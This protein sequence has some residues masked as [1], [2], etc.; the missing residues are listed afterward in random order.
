MKYNL[1]LCDLKSLLLPLIHWNTLKKS[2]NTKYVWICSLLLELK[3]LTQEG[4]EGRW[5][6]VVRW[7]RKVKNGG[8][9]KKGGEGG[10]HQ[11]SRCFGCC[12]FGMFPET[13]LRLLSPSLFVSCL[14]FVCLSSARNSVSLESKRNNPDPPLLD[15]Q[16]I[17]SKKQH[18]QSLSCMGPKTATN[19]LLFLNNNNN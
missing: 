4:E 9:V 19:F 6:M 17:Q 16:N 1:K 15:I 12:S 18:I 2:P 5:R 13:L 3:F 10:Y 14:F 11:C 8:K 7:R